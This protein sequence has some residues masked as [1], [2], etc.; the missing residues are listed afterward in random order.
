M[1]LIKVLI[2][3][4]FNNIGQIKIDRKILV[5]ETKPSSPFIFIMCTNK[6]RENNT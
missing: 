1:N 3:I 5:V 6:E 4:F 2:F